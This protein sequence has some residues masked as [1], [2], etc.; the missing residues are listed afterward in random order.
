MSYTKFLGPEDHH[1]KS[2]ITYLAHQ[3]P[4]SFWFHPPQEA[5]RSR[6]EQWK[7]KW[8]GLRPGIVDFIILEPM[9]EYHGLVLELKAGRNTPTPHQ[10]KFL[11]NAKARGYAAA[12][13]ST[14][15]QSKEILDRYFSGEDLGGVK[16]FL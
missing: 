10:E 4:E 3:Y 12:W 9:G 1:H 8:L 2:V 14:F 6:F 15:D 5:K 13:S 16:G 7:A 11:Q